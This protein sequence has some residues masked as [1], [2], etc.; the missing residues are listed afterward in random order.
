MSIVAGPSA[1]RQTDASPS[2]M[3]PCR[4][5]AASAPTGQARAQHHDALT[6]A[7]QT[8]ARYEQARAHDGLARAYQATGDCSHARRHWQQALAVYTDMGVPEAG[9]VRA[10][11]DGLSLPAKTPRGQP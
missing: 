11:L 6:L 3:P 9:Q 2:P 8:G 10:M 5:P 7:R 4:R 1:G